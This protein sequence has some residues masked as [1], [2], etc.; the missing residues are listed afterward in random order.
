[1]GD[2][3]ANRNMKGQGWRGGINQ[4]KEGNLEPEQLEI[5]SKRGSRKKENKGKTKKKW[6]LETQQLV[7]RMEG[8][9]RQGTTK[10]SRAPGKSPIEGVENRSIKKD[11]RRRRQKK[12]K[13]RWLKSST[14]KKSKV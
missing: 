14:R 10:R 11:D 4:P 8:A 2:Y 6:S 7:R 1:M 12:S 5:L 9:R 13:M 3:Y